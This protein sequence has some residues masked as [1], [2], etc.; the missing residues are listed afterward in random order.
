MGINIKGGISMLKRIAAI[1]LLV[2]MTLGLMTACT[3]EKEPISQAEA[4]AI[5]MEDLGIDNS[6]NPSI[7]VHEGEY[8]DK[9]C[10]NVYVTV[11][12]ISKTYVIAV[13]GGDIIGV[14]DGSGHSH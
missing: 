5:V 14:M 2:M 10:F 12:E 1:V 3:E 13:N 4:V 6:D 9:P 8:K 7:H 11:G